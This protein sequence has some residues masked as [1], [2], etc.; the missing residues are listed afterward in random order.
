MSNPLGGK[1]GETRRIRS[2]FAKIDRRSAP[3]KAVKARIKGY[4]DALGQPKTGPLL[5][6]KLREL[7]ELETL[8]SEMRAAALRGEHIDFLA[9]GRFQGLCRRLRIGLGLDGLPPDP[10][11]PS[12]RELGL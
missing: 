11:V 9:L 10:P 12:L 8:T 5:T 4:L 2:R 1:N 6:G 7:A 3:A